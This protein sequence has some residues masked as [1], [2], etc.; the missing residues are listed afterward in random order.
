MVYSFF[1]CMFHSYSSS[2]LKLQFK[3]QLDNLYFSGD[4]NI[5]SIESFI[6][7]FLFRNI[8]H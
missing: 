4:K 1:S 5:L 8:D 6:F 2:L 7:L 3:T